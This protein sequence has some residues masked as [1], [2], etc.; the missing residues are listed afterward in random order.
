MPPFN[1]VLSDFTLFLHKSQVTLVLGNVTLVPGDVTLVPG[2]I[3]LAPGDII[4]S[5]E[6]SRL[7]R[8]L[9]MIMDVDDFL[10]N[11]AYHK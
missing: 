6:L 9:F 10:Y 4:A 2:D 1:I 8:T 7:G 3:T 5:S 11:H